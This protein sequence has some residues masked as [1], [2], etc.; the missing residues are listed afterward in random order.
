VDSLQTAS[1][2]GDG[3]TIC[4]TVFTAKLARSV[5]TASKR[6]CASEVRR[7]VFSPTEQISVGRDIRIKGDSATAVIREQNGRVSTLSLLKQA[8]RWRIDRL[9]PRTGQ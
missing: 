7:N 8:G 6:S 5:Q 3:A 2:S 4:Q 1:R 9:T